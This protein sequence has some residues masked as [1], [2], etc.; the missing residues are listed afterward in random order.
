MYYANSYPRPPAPF[1]IPDPEIYRHPGESQSAFNRA[2]MYENFL[3]EMFKFFPN[4]YLEG[5][6]NGLNPQGREEVVS[7]DGIGTYEPLYNQGLTTPVIHGH[8]YRGI[9][10]P[11]FIERYGDVHQVAYNGRWWGYGYGESAENLF[12]E[13]GSV[14]AAS[15]NNFTN[16]TPENWDQPLNTSAYASL[17]YGS[18]SA[19]SLGSIDANMLASAQAFVNSITAL[20]NKSYYEIAMTGVANATILTSNTMQADINGDGVNETVPSIVSGAYDVRFNGGFLY[21]AG[22]VNQEQLATNL[23][24]L[25]LESR[26]RIFYGLSSVLGPAYML[27]DSL[28]MRNHIYNTFYNGGELAGLDPRNARPFGMFFGIQHSFQSF[29]QGMAGGGNLSLAGEDDLNHFTDRDGGSNGWVYSARDTVGFQRF[30]HWMDHNVNA[31]IG[32]LDDDDPAKANL[33]SLWNEY[34]FNTSDEDNS[35][36]QPYGSSGTPGQTGWDRFSPDWPDND[37]LPF[38]LSPNALNQTHPQYTVSQFAGLNREQV[39]GKQLYNSVNVW[40]VN[41]ADYMHSLEI[42]WNEGT[43]FET[44]FAL[45]MQHMERT[46]YHR[47][48]KAI[49]EAKAK[50]KEEEFEEAKAQAKAESARKSQKQYN[51]SVQAKKKEQNRVQSKGDSGKSKQGSLKDSLDRSLAR[52]YQIKQMQNAIF[53]KSKKAR[54]KKSEEA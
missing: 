52:Q 26:R 24:I 15:Y 33:N 37:H 2:V 51:E 17:L 25:M 54:S 43:I 34:R 12:R 32:N 19:P 13:D 10:S 21:E 1:P 49:R 53:N 5:L 18:G 45:M 38:G 35:Y 31:Y 27:N 8:D 47:D 46:R 14:P 39:F 7:A 42:K 4:Y 30:R 36:A 9:L 20:Q 23:M 41:W 40:A 3:A 48:Q 6:Q 11:G 16:Q 22:G 28:A 29:L 50:K 44:T